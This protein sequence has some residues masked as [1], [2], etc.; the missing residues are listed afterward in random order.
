MTLDGQVMG[1][2][3][4]KDGTRMYLELADR[5]AFARYQFSVPAPCTVTVGD[6][7]RFQVLSVRAYQ[8]QVNFEGKLLSEKVGTAK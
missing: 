1:T 5:D 4:S 3:M 2:R 7:A 6:M 8:G